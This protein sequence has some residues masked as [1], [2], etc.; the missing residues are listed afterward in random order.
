MIFEMHL[1]QWE[2]KGRGWTYNAIEC[3]RDGQQMLTAGVNVMGA[4]PRR[5]ECSVGTRQRERRHE[6][7]LDYEC[8]KV[9]GARLPTRAGLGTSTCRWH[10]GHQSTDS[11]L[12]SPGK[13][14][15]TA[16]SSPKRLSKLSRMITSTGSD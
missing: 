2:D 6:V 7:T 14:E 12:P 4:V 3:G 16:S 10:G 9:A 15:Y 5:D 13:V 11:R 8:T 1:R